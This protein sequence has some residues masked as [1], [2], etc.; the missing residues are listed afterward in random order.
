M[1]PQGTD[2]HKRAADHREA[3]R[4]RWPHSL[5]PRLRALPAALGSGQRGH[6]PDC[7]R[8]ERN[9][10]EVLEGSWFLLPLKSP[11]PLPPP[12]HVDRLLFFF[13]FPVA[14]PGSRLRRVAKLLRASVQHSIAS[15][16]Q[17]ILK[18]FTK[19]KFICPLT[20]HT[21]P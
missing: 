20:F 7:G 12:R 21:D 4:R 15:V 1:G 17:L 11:R 6:A 9:A 3:L 14:A 16:G 2:L 19:I 5:L 13:F 18:T 10:Q 8:R